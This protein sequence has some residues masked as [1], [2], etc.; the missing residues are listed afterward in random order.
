MHFIRIHLAFGLGFEEKER[1]ARV[2]GLVHSRS[3]HHGRVCQVDS[4][5]VSKQRARRR[6]LE[7]LLALSAERGRRRRMHGDDRTAHRVREG[8][9]PRV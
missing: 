8:E 1:L 4:S 2:Y 3:G 5:R 7:R 9:A 6:L